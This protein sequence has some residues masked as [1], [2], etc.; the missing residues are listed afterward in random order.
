MKKILGFTGP[1]GSG[2]DS[3]AKY[4]GE[5]LGIPFFQISDALKDIMR[6]RG[7]EI[8]RETLTVCGT[9]YAKEF[10]EDYL[11]KVLLGKVEGWER[12]NI[13]H[14]T[15]GSNKISKRKL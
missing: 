8:T 4:V 14:A 12:G 9:K 7:V 2:K 11:A 6:E 1:I 3:A 15:S 10:G 5:K 13:G